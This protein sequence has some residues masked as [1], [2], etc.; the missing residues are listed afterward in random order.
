MCGRVAGRG[1]TGL[2]LITRTTGA[3]VSCFKDKGHGFVAQGNMTITGTRQEVKQAKV[4]KIYT[5]ALTMSFNSALQVLLCKRC[6]QNNCKNLCLQELILEKVR[7]DMM[8]RAKISQSS[9]LRQKRGNTTVIQIQD[10]KESEAPVALNNND[11]Y[12]PTEINGL[13]YANGSTG[14]PEYVSDKTEELTS[15]TTDN[16]KEEESVSMDS[17][18]EISKFESEFTVF[19]TSA[20]ED[21]LHF[22]LFVSSVVFT[23]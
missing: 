12:T 11:S 19:I 9:A 7:E 3:K 14:E 8:V 5:F 20:S 22:I 10:G 6:A 13:I 15:I 2:K 23:I 21:I 17:L 18:F 1:G 16:H 4:R